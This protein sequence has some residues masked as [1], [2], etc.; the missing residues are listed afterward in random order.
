M[1]TLLG[2]S[3][4]TIST[5][6]FEPMD[7]P[8]LNNTTTTHEQSFT[9]IFCEDNEPNGLAAADLPVVYK[10]LNQ[11]EAV[12]S[13][14]ISNYWQSP[15]NLCVQLRIWDQACIPLKTEK[16]SIQQGGYP[17]V[18]VWLRT[19]RLPARP[20][21]LGPM[22]FT[23]SPSPKPRNMDICQYHKPKSSLEHHLQGSFCNLHCAS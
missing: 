8:L 17:D 2:L 23:R 11:W 14:H 1:P 21:P 10:Y 19:A 4:T 6:P 9:S 13:T 20:A 7:G 16:I 18:L 15:T 5:R 12:K 22:Y 3:S